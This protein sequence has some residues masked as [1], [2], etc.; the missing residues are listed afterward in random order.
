MMPQ[1][2]LNTVRKEDKL[3]NALAAAT[4]A[5]KAAEIIKN[6]QISL[7]FKHSYHVEA[8][9]YT[10]AHNSLT[11][12]GDKARLP[13]SVSSELCVLEPGKEFKE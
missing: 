4:E 6:R 13:L 12:Q 1:L 10:S 2:S 5:K 8:S 3:Q 7:L 11:K 9:I